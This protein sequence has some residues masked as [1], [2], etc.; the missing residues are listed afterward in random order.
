MIVEF[1]VMRNG[2]HTGLWVAARVTCLDVHIVRIGQSVG[3][4]T[5]VDLIAESWGTDV[6]AIIDCL[7]QQAITAST[8]ARRP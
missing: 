8:N 3:V 5:T 6:G 1:A 4:S 2:E 7:R